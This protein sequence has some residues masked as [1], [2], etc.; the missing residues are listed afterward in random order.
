MTGFEKQCPHL[1]QN[2]DPSY[3]R[4]ALLLALC[5]KGNLQMHRGTRRKWVK[6]SLLQYVPAGTSSCTPSCHHRTS[7]DVLPIRT[8]SGQ[9]HHPDQSQDYPC[10]FKPPIPGP[11]QGHHWGAPSIP[12]IHRKV[13]SVPGWQG[14]SA[15]PCFVLFTCILLQNIILG[16]Q[17]TMQCTT[18]SSPTQ[19]TV[20]PQGCISGSYWRLTTSQGEPETDIPGIARNSSTPLL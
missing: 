5:R 10:S 13:P 15:Q 6:C 20:A 18:A 19:A 9:K 1:G 3:V 17:K 11:Q 8:K 16:K 2:L 12:V 7:C 4:A 14:A